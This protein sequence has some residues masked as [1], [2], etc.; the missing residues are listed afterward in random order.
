MDSSSCPYTCLAYNNRNCGLQFSVGTQVAFCDIPHP[1]AWPAI[2][3]VRGWA[4]ALPWQVTAGCSQVHAHMHA[5]AAV[6]A[7]MLF[8]N[9]KI[10]DTVTARFCDTRFW[11]NRGSVTIAAVTS[12]TN[13]T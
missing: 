2:V 11:N 10:P 9:T 7:R 8:A 4:A 13:C 6:Q 1:S 5:K 3:Q 12:S